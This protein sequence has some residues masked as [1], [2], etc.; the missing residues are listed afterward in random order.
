MS[1]DVEKDKGEIQSSKEENS[2]IE[3]PIPLIA[4]FL[5]LF[6]NLLYLNSSNYVLLYGN[7]TCYCRLSPLS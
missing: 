2:L 3:H 6:C 1:I 5:R 7:R 4:L